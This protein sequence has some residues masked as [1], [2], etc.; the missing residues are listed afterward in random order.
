MLVGAAGAYY[1]S[2]L[3]ASVGSIVCASRGGTGGS[4]AGGPSD[5]GGSNA[6]S[7]KK[8]STSRADEVARKGG[9][10]GAEDLKKAL[11]GSRGAQYDLYVQPNGDVELFAKH[12]IG[13]GIETGINIKD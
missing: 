1:G 11:V 3:G 2:Q 13:E 9:Y 4:R 7:A 5:G 8:L 12:G 10:A 6:K